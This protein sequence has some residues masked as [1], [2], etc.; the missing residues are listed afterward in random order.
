MIQIQVPN[1]AAP[2]QVASGFKSSTSGRAL[3]FTEIPEGAN[4]K[5]RQH[6]TPPAGPGAWR[7]TWGS[8]RLRRAQPTHSVT[9]M[10]S[11]S[12]GPTSSPRQGMPAPRVKLEKERRNTKRRAR[13]LVVLPLA[14]RRCGWTGGG[15]ER[16][17]VGER[18]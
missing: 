7:C 9:D 1:T 16:R 4:R 12:P 13:A 8:L 3:Q 10:C 17:R 6:N 5:S 14:P 2:G 11:R 18:G 15:G